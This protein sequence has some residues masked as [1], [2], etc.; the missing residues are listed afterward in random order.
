MA[1]KDHPPG[2]RPEQRHAA[3]VQSCTEPA[4][5]RHATPDRPDP[6]PDP[7][8]GEV[9]AGPGDAGLEDRPEVNAGSPGGR[10]MS[11]SRL[12]FGLGLAAAVAVFAA[13]LA[14]VS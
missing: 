10:Q 7:R 11:N 5:E 13:I 3:A 4:G 14:L 1:G 8:T 12:G 6:R 2:G 9:P